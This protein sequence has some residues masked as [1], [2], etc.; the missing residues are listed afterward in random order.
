[1]IEYQIR[2]IYTILLNA[3]LFSQICPG[4]NIRARNWERLGWGAGWGDGYRGLLGSHLKC[5]ENI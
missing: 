5:K 4:E 2:P 1:M 3:L